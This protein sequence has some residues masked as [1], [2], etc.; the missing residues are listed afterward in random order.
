MRAPTQLPVS[1]GSG[2][3]AC[4]PDV[5]VV[6]PCYNEELTVAEVVRQFRTELPHA[7]V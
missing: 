3:P 2:E 7:R 5:A 4:A 6:I 1:G